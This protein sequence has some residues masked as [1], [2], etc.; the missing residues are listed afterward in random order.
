[1]IDLSTYRQRI[2]TFDQPGQRKT[3][4]RNSKSKCK[5]R[6]FNRHSPGLFIYLFI[7]C[8][9]SNIIPPLFVPTTLS[10]NSYPAIAVP[11]P[12]MFSPA[13][14]TVTVLFNP[15]C[16]R[17]QDENFQTRLKYLRISTLKSPIFFAKYTYGNRR[18]NGIKLCQ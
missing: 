11:R 18:S 7:L 1:M 2:G 3:S 16:S 9:I 12:D 6:T 13:P 5:K 14:D 10:Y 17:I 4:I 15:S 8:I